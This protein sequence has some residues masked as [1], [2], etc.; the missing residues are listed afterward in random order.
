MKKLLLLAIIALMM[1]LSGCAANMGQSPETPIDKLINAA[2]RGDITKV[3]QLLKEGVDVNAKNGGEYTA[4]YYAASNGKKDVVELLIANGA[5]VNIINSYYDSAT[6]ALYI[7]ANNN[8]KEIVELLIAKKADVNAPGYHGHTPLYAAAYMGNIDVAKVLIAHGADPNIQSNDGY[9]P[10]YAASLNKKA[11]SAEI[12]KLLIARGANLNTKNKHGNTPLYNAIWHGDKDYA[13]FLIT[14]G[15][16]LDWALHEAVR[17]GRQDIVKYLIAH[18]ADVNEKGYEGNTPLHFAKEHN[19]G[20]IADILIANGADVNIRNNKG[21]T[22]E[23]YAKKEQIEKQANAEATAAAKYAK[24]H[25]AQ[26]CLSNYDG[27]KYTTTVKNNCS[28]D[29]WIEVRSKD[30]FGGEHKHIYVLSP[31]ESKDIFPDSNNIDTD[32]VTKASF[33]VLQGDLK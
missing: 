30:M 17:N 9:L 2:E 3:E 4:L 8:H 20:E 26:H 6:T 22:P 25:D 13:E 19:Y 18:G 28:K 10:L 24:E 23:I 5:D 11:N 33:G 15:A 32:D 12:T 29:V 16:S 21:E 7:A 27:S 14:H 31:G 1:I